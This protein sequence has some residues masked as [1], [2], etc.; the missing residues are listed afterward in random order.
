MNEKGHEKSSIWTAYYKALKSKMSL[1]NRFENMMLFR[2][3]VM[4]FIFV[5]FLFMFCWNLKKVYNL[6]ISIT[7][8]CH[9][10]KLVSPV[11][12]SNLKNIFI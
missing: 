12:G 6:N 7:K 9:N 3:T 11:L 4:D 8:S 2:A 1:K 5:D 10:Y